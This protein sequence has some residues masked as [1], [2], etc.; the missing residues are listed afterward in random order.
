[1]N[2]AGDPRHATS[3]AV[4]NHV[5]SVACVSGMTFNPDDR[6]SRR[7][8]NRLPIPFRGHRCSLRRYAGVRADAAAHPGKNDEGRLPHEAVHRHEFPGRRRDRRGGGYARGSRAS[9]HSRSI[10]LFTPRARGHYNDK[11]ASP[12]YARPRSRKNRLRS[13]RVVRLHRRPRQNLGER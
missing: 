13:L 12:E 10:G 7:V 5:R 6:H 8:A 1:M 9:T 3:G 2:G 4:P 11:P